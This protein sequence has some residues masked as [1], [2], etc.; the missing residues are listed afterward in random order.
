MQELARE[1][2]VHFLV[3]GGLLFAG[4]AG[5]GR[6]APAASG[7]IVIDA[8]RLASLEAQFERLWRR[9]PSAP[10]RAGLIES[11]VREEV[12]YREG[13]ALGL[14]RDDPVIRRRVGQKLGFVA[15]G[16]AVQAPTEAELQAWLDAHPAEYGI[17]A[18]FSIEQAFFDPQRHGATLDAALA[19]ARAA[20]A[21]GASADSVGDRT[22]LP[23]AFERAFASELERWFGR[24][25]TEALAQLPLGSWQ[26]PVRS[27]YGLH[28]V[29]VVA[30]EDAR[31]PPLAAVR[32]EVER[33]LLDARA[34]QASEAFYQELRKRY[35]VRIEEAQASVAVAAGRP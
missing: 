12:L 9:P 16:L 32:A 7:E 6:V 10:E 11:F 27:G 22:P 24:G 20:L 35:T 3:L 2:L 5:L 4:Y 33:D 1:P 14:D 25:W 26:G 8:G 13:L 29:R 30:R 34:Q 19:G 21:N 15:D 18:R 23:A 31:R 28:L 17:E